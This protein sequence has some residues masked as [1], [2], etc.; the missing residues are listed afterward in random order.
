MIKRR[1]S[2]ILLNCGKEL[3]G[4]RLRNRTMSRSGRALW[5]I[6]RLV[7]AVASHIWTSSRSER[8]FS[9]SSLA[10]GPSSTA[11]LL[12]EKVRDRDKGYIQGFNVRKTSPMFD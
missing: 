12:E 5:N 4:W 11:D 6:P 2:D 3:W 10:F 8:A 1:S 7:I 9:S